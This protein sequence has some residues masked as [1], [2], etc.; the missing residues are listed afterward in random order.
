MSIHKFPFAAKHLHVNRCGVFFA[1]LTYV[2]QPKFS[3]SFIILFALVAVFTAGETSAFAAQPK[4]KQAQGG[5][6][7]ATQSQSSPQGVPPSFAFNNPNSVLTDT[8]IHQVCGQGCLYEKA[9]ET[10]SLQALYLL[11]KQTALNVA[12]SNCAADVGKCAEA[13][14]ELYPVYCEDPND[15]DPDTYQGNLKGCFQHYLIM[16]TPVL[17]KI[18][19]AIATN[20]TNA[21][22]LSDGKIAVAE[23]VYVDSK[24][25]PQKLPQTPNP[26]RLAVINALIQQAQQPADYTRWIDDP[27]VKPK[28]PTCEDYPLFKT[29]R[30]DPTHPTAGE[31]VTIVMD[32]K[33]K[34]VC[35]H[36]KFDPINAAYFGSIA[37]GSS[38]NKAVEKDYNDL[39]ARK[40]HKD[41]AKLPRRSLVDLKTGKPDH[42]I[43]TEAYLA[44]ENKVVSAT[45]EVLGRPDFNQ[46]AVAPTPPPAP[47]PASP[48]LKPNRNLA[49]K[50]PAPASKPAATP[51]PKA[52][53]P[54]S[55][56]AYSA[57]ASDPKAATTLPKLDANREAI[58]AQPSQRPES[59]SKSLTVGYSVDDL[60]QRIEDAISHIDPL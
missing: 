22:N 31:F 35:D 50:T 24:Q 26:P 8:K 58:R 17:Q 15:S 30:R 21:K 11:E 56:T 3:Q 13:R 52:S 34:P 48:A 28:K 9:N 38:K 49:A 2:F 42:S 7:G 16:T 41:L 12:I 36:K 47:K 37:G 23:P 29:E 6:P 46:P 32:E 40:T 59:D 33:G 4:S 53:N 55:P 39:L 25:I 54:S 43:S 19:V 1:P 45:N 51:I 10:L 5:N 27:N 44:A 14:A 57:N 60:D 20:S 18:K